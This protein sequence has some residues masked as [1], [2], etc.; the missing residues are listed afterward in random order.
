VGGGAHRVGEAARVAGGEELLG[1]R[2]VAALATHLLWRAELEV[3]LAVVGARV[4][5]AAAFRGGGDGGVE[6]FHAPAD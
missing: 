6:D 3:D 2:A 4:A 5:V 1:V